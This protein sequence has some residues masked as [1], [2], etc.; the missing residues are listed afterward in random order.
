MKIPH[1]RTIHGDTVVDNYFHL[2]DRQH[3]DTLPFLEAENRHTE[4]V[5]KP[6]EP[7]QKKLYDEMLGRIE[8]TDSS[9]PAPQG[10]FEYYSRT[11]ASKQDPILCRRPRATEP[12]GE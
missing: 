12:A 5:M 9:V 3:P 10:N 4:E 7:L 6:L 8:E 1:L 11:E 2:R